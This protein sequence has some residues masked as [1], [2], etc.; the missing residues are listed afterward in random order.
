MKKTLGLMVVLSLLAIPAAA[1]K[2]TIDY[3]HD[4]DFDSVKSFTFVDTP[5][6][7]AG[8]GLTDQ[9]IRRA[10]FRAFSVGPLEPSG[11]LTMTSSWEALARPGSSRT[12]FVSSASG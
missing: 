1:Q 8:D 6:T 12:T 11:T 3:A 9:R 7:N 10:I 5:D 2:V 4:F